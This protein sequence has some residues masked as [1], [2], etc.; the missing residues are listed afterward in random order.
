MQ[1]GRFDI[2][3]KEVRMKHSVILYGNKNF[4]F[5]GSK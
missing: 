2:T 4:V 1:P 3:K 5:D